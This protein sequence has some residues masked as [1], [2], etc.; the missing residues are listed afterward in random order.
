MK[1]LTHTQAAE[2]LFAAGVVPAHPQDAVDLVLE[3]LLAHGAD[4]SRFA[5]ELAVE[6]AR[7]PETAAAHM[8]RCLAVVPQVVEVPE[9]PSRDRMD[10]VYTGLGDDS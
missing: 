4:P 10:A 2:L 6:Y 9:W 3:Q 8:C 1:L 5:D 7:H